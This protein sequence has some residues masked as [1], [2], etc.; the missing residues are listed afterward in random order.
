M[1][2]I[3]ILYLNTF[4]QRVTEFGQE[5]VC[6]NEFEC[7]I[8]AWNRLIECSNK[9]LQIYICILCYIELVEVASAIEKKPQLSSGCLNNI[10]V[11]LPT[12]CQAN[13]HLATMVT[14]VNVAKTISWIVQLQFVCWLQLTLCPWKM[15]GQLRSAIQSK[16]Q[17]WKQYFKIHLFFVKILANQNKRPTGQKKMPTLFGE[18]YGRIASEC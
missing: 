16:R 1:K 2:S 9:S 11:T 4:T 10:A 15:R 17:T 18:S 13:T 6:L 7:I 3:F 12:Q 5:W 8:W 14:D